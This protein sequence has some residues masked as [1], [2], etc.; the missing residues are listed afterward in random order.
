MPAAVL[1]RC[2]P[3]CLLI[4]LR[5]HLISEAFYEIFPRQHWEIEISRPAILGQSYFVLRYKNEDVMSFFFAGEKVTIRRVDKPNS[6]KAD[7][8][9]MSDVYLDLFE[10]LAAPW[11]ILES[12]SQNVSP[13]ARKMWSH[14]ESAPRGLK[15]QTASLPFSI[16]R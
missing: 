16:R 11:G 6:M 8:L 5:A 3:R 7:G 9:K 15:V 13:S 12:D 14:I 4:P 1:L 2:F 10:A